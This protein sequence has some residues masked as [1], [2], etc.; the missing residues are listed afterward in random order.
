VRHGEE[1]DEGCRG[2]GAGRAG[3]SSQDCP[4]RTGF[5]DGYANAVGAATGRP[6]EVDNLSQHSH[7]TLP[8]LLG[9]V[10]Q[11]QGKLAAADIIVVGI[12]H[13]SNERNADRPCGKPLKG[14]L[15][16]W[17]Y[18]ERQC[19]IRSAQRFRPMYDQLYSQIASWRQGRPTI[20]Q[21]INRYNDC[22]RPRRRP[23]PL[24][25]AGVSLTENLLAA[26]P[27]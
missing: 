4:G 12:A 23:A 27:P 22:N 21:T 19:A 25:W 7:L 17:P 9:E 6:V 8:G 5:V 18:M 2:W 20:L 10:D 14:D 26:S 24:R 13:N 1:D 15:P 11:F 16:D 3:R